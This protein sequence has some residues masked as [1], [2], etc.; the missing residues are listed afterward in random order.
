[1]SVEQEARNFGNAVV[2]RA[3]RNLGATRTVNGKKRR[4]VASGNLKNNLIYRVRIDHKNGVATVSFGAKPSL[5]I[6]PQVVEVGRRRGATPPPIQP[7][8][9]WMK[10]KRIVSRDK[11]GRVLK[12]VY[13]A[14]RGKNKGK[15]VD[16][17]W[18]HA[19]M[20]SKKI[21]REGIPAL[22][23]YRDA[24]RDEV[25]D[26]STNFIKAFADSIAKANV[27]TFGKQKIVI[28]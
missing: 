28:K 25:N 10:R 11:S 1:M 14:T 4:A 23:Y 18:H 26:P 24:I 17:R 20:I 15:E 19:S 27:K 22:H 5:G 8:Y 13:I 6:Y 2:E 12:Q 9:D 7:I 16:R 21:G 3:Q